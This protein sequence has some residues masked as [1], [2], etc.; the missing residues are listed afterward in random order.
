MRRRA[1]GA[2]CRGVRDSRFC[3]NVLRSS[4]RPL[5]AVVKGGLRPKEAGQF[6]AALNSP[7]AA[8]S[9]RVRREISFPKADMTMSSS[10]GR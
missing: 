8:R 2:L 1:G 6:H 9:G 4:L 7:V 5:D 10:V 3:G